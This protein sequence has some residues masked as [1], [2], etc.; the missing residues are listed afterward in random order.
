MG[1][2]CTWSVLLA[3]EEGR[4][5]GVLHVGQRKG[6]VENLELQADGSFTGETLPGTA[7]NPVLAEYKIWGQ[8][9]GD[10]VSVTVSSARCPPRSVSARRQP[11]GY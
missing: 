11:V 4:L 5:T 6:I 7:K 9:T 10:V 1:Q 8:F 2:R 3:V